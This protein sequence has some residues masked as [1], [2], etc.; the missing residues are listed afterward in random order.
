MMR[1]ALGH[2]STSGIPFARAGGRLTPSPLVGEGWGEGDSGATGGL[3][4]S[5]GTASAPPALVGKPPVAPLCW[6]LAAAACLV[7]LPLPLGHAQAPGVESFARPP[8]TPAET[9]ERIDY[10]V[11]VGQPA[12]AVPFLKQFA[13]SN[14]DDTTMVA[15]RDEYGQASFFRLL[16]A[17]ETRPYAGPLLARLAEAGRRFATR[18]ERL[19]AAIAMLSKSRE[20]RSYGVERLREAGPYAVPALVQALAQPGLSSDDRT[21]LIGGLGA[22]GGSAVAPLVATLDAPD[23]AIASAAAQALGTIRDRGAIPPLTAAAALAPEPARNSARRAIAKITGAPFETQPESPAKVL[24]DAARVAFLA[25]PK[26]PEGPAT[27]WVWDD[28]AKAPAPRPTTRAEAQS[29]ASAKLARWALAVAPADRRAQATLLEVAL[30]RDP[31]GATSEALA[32]GPVVLAE[33]VRQAIADGRSVPAAAAVTALGQVTDRNALG[34]GARPGALVEA[35]DAPDR[36]VQFAAARALVGLDPGRPFPGSSRVVPTL[37]RFVAA[38]P[39]PRAVVIDG[40]PDRGS[41]LVGYLKGLGYDAQIASTGEQGFRMA[42]DTVDVE[43][44]AIDPNF[45]QGHWRLVDTLANLRADPQTAGIPTFLYGELAM[46]DRLAP[47]LGSFPGVK[48]LI[49]PTRMDLFQDEVGRG[50]VALRAK[51]LSSD[52]RAAFAKEAAELLAKVAGRTGEPFESE[53]VLAAP[54]LMLALNNP[55]IAPDVV[56]AL[57]EVP[58]T[59]AQR[60]L[61]DVVLNP[62][63]AAALRVG[64][65]EALARSLRRFGTL[66][67]PGQDARL[68]AELDQA[69]EPTL[70]TALSAVVGALKPK[71]ASSGRR[72]QEFRPSPIVPAPAPSPAPAPGTAAPTAAPAP[73]P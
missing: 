18:P 45:V 4:T 20:E 25:I 59:E 35:L 22:L 33:V 41:L 51:P 65:A 46:H 36:R 16:D 10:L 40:N 68:A 5:A 54:S 12:Q 72:L 69:E 42:A 23:P 61:V 31:A 48:L 73:G 3:P 9:W 37:A 66:L 38:G 67:A 30:E 29:A 24:T 63:N 47:L 49:T 19:K 27:A 56:K 64:A 28:A 43:L 15:I 71:A 60:V 32:A 52:E 57:G 11:R 7:L 62:S 6:A 70:R 26:E 39:A 44:I 34:D 55:A 8:Q 13:A 17:P 21:A 50:L 1:R 14:P 58:R 2:G 53:L